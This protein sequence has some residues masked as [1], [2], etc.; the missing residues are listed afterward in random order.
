M[1]D[2]KFSV[3][4]VVATALISFIISGIG[5][6]MLSE[7]LA[8]PK[9]LLTISAIGFSGTEHQIAIS[10][11]LQRATKESAWFPNYRKYE[12]FDTLSED[13]KKAERIKHRLERGLLLV[14]DWLESNETALQNDKPLTLKELDS[15]PYMQDGIV[16][17]SL[18][19]MARR[20]ELSAAPIDIDVVKQGTPVTELVKLSD[21]YL[22]YMGYK[23]VAFPF[24]S[25]DTQTEKEQ[26]ERLA[27]SF[28]F[29]NGKNIVYYMKRMAEAS[30][31]D[32]RQMV[33][34]MEIFEG[35]ML[36]ATSLSVRAEIFNS[37]RTP[38]VVKPY[39]LVRVLN[40]DIEQKDH[41]LRLTPLAPAE[42]SSRSRGILDQIA[43]LQG[44]NNSGSDVIV[45]GFLPAIEDRSYVLVPPNDSISLQLT[46]DVALGESGERLRAIYD[47]NVLRAKLILV[48]DAGD[49]IQ[50]GAMIFGASANTDVQREL[51]I[52]E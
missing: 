22:L 15:T 9:P 2:K 41:L 51:T 14:E 25:A 30:N 6:A 35:S 10:D 20:G 46:S 27:Y 32:I 13:Y 19:G 44:A 48:T 8:R 16:G 21:R 28:A 24:G 12:S 4:T 1:A 43:G 34:L 11:S 39:A 17:S 31:R 50:S 23:N 33:S 7:W 40:D 36:P 26:I 3:T 29:G 5:G 18:V 38:L 37:G 45:E 42:D 49:Q 52:I 47:A